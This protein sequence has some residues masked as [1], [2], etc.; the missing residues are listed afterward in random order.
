MLT[1]QFKGKGL[2]VN[3]NWWKPTQKEWAPILLQEQKP[4]WRR[5]SDPSTGRPRAK[6]TPN[7]AK[8]NAV[9]FPGEPIL[10]ATGKMEDEAE[11]FTYKDLFKVRARFYGVFHQF[12]TKKMAARPWMGVPDTALDKLPPIAWKHIFSK[13][14]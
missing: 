12:G 4:F 1:M 9:L 3:L 10:R 14:K 7:Y 13:M 6:L 5:E 2:V 11:I 8:R